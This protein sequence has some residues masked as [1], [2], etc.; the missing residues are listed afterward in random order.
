MTLI[1][2]TI[3]IFI[4]YLQGMINGKDWLLHILILSS[5]EAV[6]EFISGVN[7]RLQYNLQPAYL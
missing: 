2:L 7:I 3:H 5:V 1:K 4:L 6:I